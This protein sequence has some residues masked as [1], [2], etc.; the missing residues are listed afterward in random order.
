MTMC[1]PEAPIEMV[2]VWDTVKA[3]GLRLPLLWML[4]EVR[5]AF[6]NHHLGALDPA[7]VS[8]A[9]AG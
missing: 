3:L 5:H 4:T 6:H 2:G 1:H 9:G 8:R 7:R